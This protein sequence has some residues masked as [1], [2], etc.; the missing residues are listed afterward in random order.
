MSD[1]YPIF[2]IKNKL[3]YFVHKAETDGPVA[4][5]R[6]EKEVAFIISK[7]DYEKLSDT[8][9][10]KEFI[11]EAAAR[12]R[13]SFGL[14]KDDFDYTEYFEKIRHQDCPEALKLQEEKRSHIFDD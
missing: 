2:I 11:F 1:A 9:P 6:R 10:K 14:E 12:L 13:K 8:A 7:D 4:I 5:S 3:P